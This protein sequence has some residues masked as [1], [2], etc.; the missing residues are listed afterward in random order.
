MRYKCREQKSS[1]SL[2]ALIILELN[3]DDFFASVLFDYLT[4]DLVMTF[5]AHYDSHVNV[6]TIISYVSNVMLTF[7]A[8]LNEK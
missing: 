6:L 2:T 8:S 5:C 4:I 1:N 7:V 3:S